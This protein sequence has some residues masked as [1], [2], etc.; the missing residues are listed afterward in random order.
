[1]TISEGRRRP[2]RPS[3]ETKWEIYLQVTS[4]AITLADAALLGAVAAAAKRIEASP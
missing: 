1:M 3:A 4:V 2:M